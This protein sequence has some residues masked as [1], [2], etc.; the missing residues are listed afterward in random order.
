MG[1]SITELLP[2]KE[3]KLEE[4]SGNIIAV[5]ASLFIYQFLSTIRQRDGTPLM[6]SKGRI[7]SHLSGIFQRTIKL[8]EKGIKPVF[9]FDGE[10]PELKNKEKE[11]RERLKHEAGIKYKE[12]AEKEDIAAMKK[13]A[14]RT[15]KL[16]PEMVDE[17]KQL[18]KSMGVPVVQAPSEGEAQAAYMVKKGDAYAIASSD[19]D[20]LLFGADRVVKNRISMSRPRVSTVRSWPWT[21]R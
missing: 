19:V 18:L 10:S 5:D 4:L 16:T 9:V 17:A 14:M 7:T 12:A 8:L 15:S 3:I 21:R 11:K 2:S 6:D 20:S 1:V 13:Y